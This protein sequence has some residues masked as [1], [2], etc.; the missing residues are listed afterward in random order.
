MCLGS[1]SLTLSVRSAL[2]GG[3]LTAPLRSAKPS[4][5]LYCASFSRSLQACAHV[6]GPSCISY[7]SLTHPCA[8]LVGVLRVMIFT[9]Q[10][11]LHQACLLCQSKRKAALFNETHITLQTDADTGACYACMKICWKQT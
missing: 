1:M 8:A 10:H 6:Q 4:E 3:T 11:T 2:P 9:R 5:A 7:N